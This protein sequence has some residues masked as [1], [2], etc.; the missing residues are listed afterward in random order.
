MS[1]YS[2]EKSFQPGEANG[3]VRASMS[4]KEFVKKY[5]LYRMLEKNIRDQCNMTFIE[6]REVVL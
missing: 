1:R 6:S 5:Q 3:S 2:R 4:L